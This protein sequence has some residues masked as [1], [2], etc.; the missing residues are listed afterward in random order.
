MDLEQQYE[1]LDR[2][3]DSILSSFDSHFS[4]VLAR[5]QTRT[6]VQLRNTLAV[7][8]DGTVRP[9][10]ANVRVL[11]RLPDMFRRSLS[12]EGYDRLINSFIGSFNGGLPTME[13]ILA[14]IAE[15]YDV[16][17]PE[18]TAQ[19][20]AFFQELKSGVALNFE[21]SVD[22]VSQG[23]R[24]ATTFSVAGSPFEDLAV[25]L[26]GRLH[27]ALGQAQNIA[28]TG[29]S[30]FYRT[31]AAQGYKQIDDDLE[32]HGKQLEY[33]YYGPLDKL[34]RPFCRRLEA[35]ARSGKTWN[36]EE[37][38]KMN[39]EQL[40]DCFTTAGGYRCRHQWIVAME[41]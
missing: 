31:V 25:Q 22:L 6:S 41:R 14:T 16:A 20:Q 3:T 34:N 7:E 26:A 11:R 38:N 28:A 13:A 8:A 2:R 35:L 19:D 10:A 12:S 36:R 29:I 23:A 21:A 17:A 39:N 37:I 24:M 9:T 27:L 33:S 18:F 5:A 32:P 4:S 40:P 30:T 15:G 1:N